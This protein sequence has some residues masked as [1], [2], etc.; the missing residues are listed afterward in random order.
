MGVYSEII[1]REV[2][3]W[4]NGSLLYKKWLNQNTSIVFNNYGHPTRKGE[5]VLSITDDNVV[6]YLLNKH[7]KKIGQQKII[8]I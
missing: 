7:C 1:G 5:G 8:G 4:M 3:V 6:G 2:Y